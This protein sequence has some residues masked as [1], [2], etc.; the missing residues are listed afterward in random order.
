M[1]QELLEAIRKLNDTI[2]DLSKSLGRGVSGTGGVNR[3]S[4][5]VEDAITGSSVLAK[6]LKNLSTIK[7]NE[8]NQIVKAISMNQRLSASQ[9]KFLKQI[10][11]TAGE[12]KQFAAA[13]QDATAEQQKAA[14]L[15]KEATEDLVQSLS[16]FGAGLLAGSRDLESMVGGLGASLGRQD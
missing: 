10:N 9:E 1:E 14:K 2:A 6:T 15:Q 11:V 4:S 8:F 3:G 7:R 5:G 13:T 12:V 16:G